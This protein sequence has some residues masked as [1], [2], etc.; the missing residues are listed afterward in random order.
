MDINIR[1]A[2]EAGQGVASAGDLLAQSL[3]MMGLHVL[4]T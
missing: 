4:A 1:V 2:G 3:A